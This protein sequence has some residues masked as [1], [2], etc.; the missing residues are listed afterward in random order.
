MTYVGYG[1]KISC[2]YHWKDKLITNNGQKKKHYF[3][4]FEINT[5]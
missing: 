5:I 4:P 3:W 1:A 2:T